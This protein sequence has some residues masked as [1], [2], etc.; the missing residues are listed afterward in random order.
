MNNNLHT[1][2]DVL[3]VLYIVQELKSLYESEFAIS[4]KN[5]YQKFEDSTNDFQRV[6][7]VLL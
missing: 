7:R 3:G 2:K 5:A 1:E 6:L 4:S